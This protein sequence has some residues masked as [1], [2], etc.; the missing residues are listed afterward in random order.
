MIQANNLDNVHVIA[1][2]II[3][4]R[5]NELN[6]AIEHAKSK[7]KS[8]SEDASEPNSILLNNDQCRVSIR[9]YVPKRLGKGY[10]DLICIDPMFYMTIADV[11]YDQATKF[12]VPNEQLFKIRSICEG[13]ILTANPHLRSNKS[14]VHIQF[15]GSEANTDIVFLPNTPTK[16]ISL[17]IS[18]HIW[19][20]MG[21]DEN[22]LPKEL[23]KINSESSHMNTLPIERCAPLIRMSNEILDSRKS[24]PNKFR[25]H[26]LR[27]KALE[28]FS[29]SMRKL[30]PLNLESKTG[31]TLKE[32][33]I[34]LVLEAK[35]IIATSLANPP[36]IDSISRMVGMNRT[37]L[38]AQ[39]K[40]YMGETIHNF[41]NRIRMEKAAKQLVET[42]LAIS[43]IA[44]QIGFK[45]PANFT[46]AIKRHFNK[47][48]RDFR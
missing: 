21:I 24:M 14:T 25:I 22:I 5:L 1:D 39:F 7:S 30:L 43:E 46:Q 8:T 32:H 19:P 44:Y 45:H 41:Q 28:L 42:D 34:A 9:S 33:D 3:G 10:W 36:T 2:S 11:E 18:P 15:G 4:A 48:P 37:K 27:G 31:K 13:E 35:R 6:L 12:K 20:A 17:I 29:E 40:D 47:A 23:T 38:K 26:Y 16:L